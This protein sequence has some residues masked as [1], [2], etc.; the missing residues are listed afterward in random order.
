MGIEADTIEAPETAAGLLQK[1]VNADNKIATIRGQLKQAEEEYDA[2]EDRIFKL[3]DDQGTEAI[4]N[5]KIGIQVSINSVD[6]DTIED[7]DK[8]TAFVLRHKL[9]HFFQR[10]L[11]VAALRE[12]RAHNSK[13]IPGLGVFPKRRLH[14]TTIK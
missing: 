12:Y 4:R 10:R 1:L 5:S 3:M 14:V 2:V 9:L 6:V 11:A 13:P 7:Y 8:F